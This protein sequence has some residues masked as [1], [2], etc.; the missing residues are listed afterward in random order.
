MK[1]LLLILFL[2]AAN[3]AYAQKVGLVLSG[4]GA[5]GLA[6]IGVLKALEENNIP[7]DYIAGTSMGGVVGAMYAAGYSPKEIEY[8]ALSSDFQ[9]WVSGKYTSDYSYFFKKKE[10]NPS[11][12][13]AKLQIDT[14]FNFRFRSNLV[15]DIPLNFALLELLGQ[16]SA[17]AK[18]NF[19]KLFVPYR[20]VVADV[21]SQK[22][23]VMKEGSL[24]EA[25]RGTF[26]VPLVYRPIKVEEKYVFDGGLY[27]NFPVDVMKKEFA[28]DVIIGSNVSSKTF[29]TY[30][31]DI[32]EKLMNKFLM[33]LFLSKTDSTAIGENGVYIQPDLTN[34]TATNFTPVEELIKKGYDATIAELEKINAKVGRRASEEKVKE[35]RKAFV[36]KNPYFTFKN[37]RISGVSGKRKQYVQS[38]FK[39]MNDDLSLRDVK[40]AYY[41]LLGDDNFETVYPKINYLPA[42]NTYEFELIVQPEKNFRID[43]GGAVSNRPVGTAFIGLQYN[44]LRRQSYTLS[45]NFYT[46]RFHESAQGAFRIDI[47]KKAPFYLESELTY[48]HWNFFQSSQLFLEDAKPTF[49]EQSDSRFIQNIGFSTGK[50]AKTLIFGGVLSNTNNYSPIDNFIT[51]ADLDKTNFNGFTAGI[52]YQRDKLNRKQYASKGNKLFAGFSYVNGTEKY[53][54]GDVFKDEPIYPSLKPQKNDRQWFV[55]KISSEKYSP[56]SRKYSI[57]YQFEGVYSNRPDFSSYKSNLLYAS[58]FYPLSDSKTLFLESLRADKYLSA[59]IKNV[60]SATRHL[61]FRLEGYIFQPYQ[62]IRRSGLQATNYGDAL[63]SRSFIFTGAAVYHSPVGP[64]ALNF[65]YYDDKPKNFG[66]FFHIGYLIYNKRALEL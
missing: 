37:I 17:N 58:P 56:I 20:C 30:P 33:Y 25:V 57:G 63:S 31:K 18:N 46:G 15:N 10:D 45:A 50:S 64:I 2:F 14:G 53:Y 60:Y 21:L 11:F 44:F 39:N 29:N 9:N 61:D 54:P 43:F 48:N 8:I 16:A 13:T 27:N 52:K 55:A 32:D 6:H 59:G 38:L 7:I 5:K 26:T 47:P 3:G 12:I 35:E 4:G 62:E 42:E 24:V 49:L 66:V 19:N 40:R 34:Y 51:G 1:K 65:N 36:A 28:P 23:I 22:A 41:K